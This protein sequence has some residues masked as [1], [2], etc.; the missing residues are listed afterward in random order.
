VRRFL[1]LLLAVL[2]TLV[3]ALP[4]IADKPD[5]PDKPTQ[6]APVAVSLGGSP[7][8]VHE[9]DDVIWYSVTVVN[10]GRAEIT[11]D[12]LYEGLKKPITVEAK[13]AKTV[14]NLFSRDV[15]PDDIASC[16]DDE[17]EI[18]DLF[19]E[20][21][22]QYPDDGD[23][24]AVVEESTLVDPVDECFF[25]EGVPTFIESG[26]CIWKPGLTD[27]DPGLTA[28][29]HWTL[30]AVPDP[31]PSRRTN[32]MMTMRD[33]VPGNWCTL[34]DGSGGMIQDQWLKTSTSVDLNVYLPSHGECW[35]GGHGVC[36]EPDCYFGVGNPESF[37]LYTAFDATIKVT[38][39]PVVPED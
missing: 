10:K 26:L 6:S 18:C 23:V 38:K 39:T 25:D 35:T 36:L 9:A 32:L 5:K 11:V 2:M 17:I 4:A 3:I 24:I 29:E 28:T 37:Y 22:V 27:T 7:M 12:V 1:F 13:S 20:V 8:W 14:E 19:T 16:L 30:S 33:G 15:T 21:T 34:I 31:E